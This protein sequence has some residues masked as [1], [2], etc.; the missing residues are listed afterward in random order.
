MLEKTL[1]SPLDYKEIKPVNP[2]GS[3][4]WIFTGRTDAEAEAPILWLPD[5]KSGLIGTDSDT[6]KDW[7]EGEKG[8]T[9]IV[10]GRE[11]WHT[12]LCGDA[13]SLRRLS[14]RTTTRERPFYVNSWVAHHA[15]TATPPGWVVLVAPFCFVFFPII[16]GYMCVPAITVHSISFQRNSWV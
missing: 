13:K 12:A 3:Q 1:E 6:E 15:N 14:N 5:V 11:A 8:M 7:G 9:E 16:S 2:K 4:P 10:K